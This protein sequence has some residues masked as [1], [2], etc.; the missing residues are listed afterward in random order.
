MTFRARPVARRPGRSGW[1]SGA[2][3]STLINAGFALAIVVSVLILVGYAGWTWYDNHF[4]AA[5]S[6]N[7]SVITNDDVRARLAIEQFRIQYT[8]GQVTA[9]L[10]AGHITQ[11]VYQ[12]EITF[13]NQ[14]Q[15]QL[16]SISL[17]KLIDIK[18]QAS[19]AADEGVS[20]TDADIQ[21]ELTKEATTDEERHVWVIEV[22]PATDPN[23]G[24]VGDSQKADAKAKADKA[25][26]DLKAGKTWDDIAKTVSTAASAPQAGDIGWIT[27]DSGYDAKL[28]DAVFGLAANTTT[29]VIL[30]DDGTYRIGRVTDIAPS[31]VDGRFATKLDA[32]GIKMADYLVAVKADVVRNKLSDKVVADLSAPGPQRHVLQIKLNSTTPDPLAVKTRHILFAPKHDPDNASKLDASDPAWQ[33]AQDLAT[34]AYRELVGDPSK[35]D[36]MARSTQ[37]DDPIARAAGGK[38]DWVDPTT[39]GLD[40]AFAKAVFVAGLKPG[41][42]LPPFKTS[43][44]WDVVQIQRP[45]G[46]G[47]QAWLNTIKTRADAGEDFG[48]LAR[49]QGEGDEAAK[50]GDLGWIAKGQLP[51]GEEQ[52]IFAATVGSTTAV[53][54]IANDG[55]YLWKVL[56]EETKTPDAE[57]IKTF[58]DSG[59]TNWYSNKKA[60][61]TITR[62]TDTSAATS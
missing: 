29:D 20:V 36:Q 56:A 8:Q 26:A 16:A 39:Q 2:R 49:D 30:G 53:T 9:Q 38:L 62:A 11:T 57:Q 41:V 17:E 34:A 60:G 35:F 28:M 21:A 58:K 61:A 22:E 12:Q 31:S 3:R 6:V 40:P 18:L 27:K 15:Q 4:G 33:T 46:D 59:F 48:A 25:L 37:N 44:G 51:L 14:R 45:Y 10:N 23:T 52:A 7:G 32:A 1:D 43:S 50:G 55:D 13:L 42:I 24:V 19:L 5:G 54:D 47:N